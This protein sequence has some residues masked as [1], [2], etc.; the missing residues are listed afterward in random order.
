VKN[1]RL[2][3]MSDR[4]ENRFTG[5]GQP[6]DIF[7]HGLPLDNRQQ[8]V[9]D[10]L[11]ETGSR[12]VFGKEDVSMLDLSALTAKTGDEFAMFTRG[13]ER[14][15]IRGG[16]EHVNIGLMDAAELSA[17]GYKWSGHTHPGG[18]ANFLRPS[19]GD[20]VILNAFNQN[21][22][23]IYNSVGQYQTFYK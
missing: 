11:P 2:F 21:T 15:V 13:S 12:A 6:D 3:I 19:D 1:I 23:V 16:K 4:I 22:S 20:K 18:N 9:L 10:E 5:V 17:Q 7:R 8:R 14:L